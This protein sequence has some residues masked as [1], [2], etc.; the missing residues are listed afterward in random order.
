MFKKKELAIKQ[1]VNYLKVN[2]QYLT[3]DIIA[4]SS[5]KNSKQYPVWLFYK[6]NKVNITID[7]LTKIIYTLQNILYYFE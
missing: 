2:N 1:T 3:K 6:I 7:K 4:I 5:A